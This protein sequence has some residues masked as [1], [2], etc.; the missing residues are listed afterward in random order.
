MMNIGLEYI[1]ILFSYTQKFYE[2]YEEKI[3]ILHLQ[4][5]E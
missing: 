4:F 5:V 2:I 3:N 1:C